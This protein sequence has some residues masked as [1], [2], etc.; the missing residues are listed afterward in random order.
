M[1]WPDNSN[2]NIKPLGL[3]S[4]QQTGNIQSVELLGVGK[5]EFTRDGES[6]NVKLPSGKPC[7]HAFALKIS[8]DNLV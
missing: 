6:L 7:D 8:G 3:N 5:L 2:L 4:K 1:G